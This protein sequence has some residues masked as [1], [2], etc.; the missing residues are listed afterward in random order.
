MINAM[1]NGVD[2]SSLIA[3]CVAYFRS[4]TEGKTVGD[5]TE[6]TFPYMDSN[7]DCLNLYIK[8]I[9]S[10]LFEVTDCGSAFE[11]LEMNGINLDQVK[12]IIIRLTSAHGVEFS[13]GVLR[14]LSSSDLLGSNCHRML[15]VLIKL[16]TLQ[17]LKY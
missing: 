5:Y 8:I 11:N 13:G 4:Q 10:D 16:D 1:N 3:D 7:N 14:L 12:D 17:Y 2:Q 9:G 15:Q 6:I